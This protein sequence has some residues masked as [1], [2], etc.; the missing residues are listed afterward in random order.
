QDVLFL[1]SPARWQSSKHENWGLRNG[2][3]SMFTTEGRKSWPYQQEQQTK[4]C[5][6]RTRGNRVRCI[7]TNLAVMLIARSMGLLPWVM[8]ICAAIILYCGVMSF[9]NG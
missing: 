6:P 2:F 1:R 5:S 7:F 3:S 8:K 4:R 9:C